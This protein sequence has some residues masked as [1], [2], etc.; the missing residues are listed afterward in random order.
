[1]KRQIGISIYPDHSS[2]DE[3]KAYLEWRNAMDLVE[4]L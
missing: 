1:M 4:F 3:D 2:N